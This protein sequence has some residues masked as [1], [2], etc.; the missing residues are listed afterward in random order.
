MHPSFLPLPPLICSHS[1]SPS[2][3]F[4]LSYLCQGLSNE[5]SSVYSLRQVGHTRTSTA[6]RLRPVLVIQPRTI[7]VSSSI[8]HTGSNE[9]PQ[10][11]QVPYLLI[12]F[13]HFPVAQSSLHHMKHNKFL[14]I[15]HIFYNLNIYMF[16]LLALS[17]ALS[18]AVV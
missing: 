7:S 13:P 17:N 18:S 8:N 10:H 12:P 3:L 1:F 5:P 14:P 2:L 15:T 9:L 11:S 6:R 16:H 4:V